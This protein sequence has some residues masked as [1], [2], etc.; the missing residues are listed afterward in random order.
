M[1]PPPLAILS[2]VYPD[3]NKRPRRS[4]LFEAASTILAHSLA[5][6]NAGTLVGVMPDGHLSLF[7]STPDDVANLNLSIFDTSAPEV[8]R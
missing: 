6:D 1:N 2:L 8:P 5:H 3:R 7:V 4:D